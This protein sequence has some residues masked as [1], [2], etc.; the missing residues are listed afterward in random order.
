MSKTT[1]IHKKEAPER[2]KVAVITV[3]DTKSQNKEEDTS[4][5]YIK[6][7]LKDAGHE[8]ISYK[9]VPDDEATIIEAIDYIMEKQSPDAIITTGGTGISKR[10]VTIEA[11]SSMLEKVL[12]GF[13][14]LFR[15][16]SHKSIGGAVVATRAIAGVS[17]G[18]VIFSLPGSPDAVRTGMDII[19]KEIAHIV[20][21][22]RE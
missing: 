12:E 10:D 13:G 2:V 19:L 11:V 8:V 5:T 1:D 15:S 4:G 22:A 3:S 20:K 14:E 18:T 9:I 7:A 6:D 17:N 16:N 21:H